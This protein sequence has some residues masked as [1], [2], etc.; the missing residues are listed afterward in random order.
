MCQ[1][2]IRKALFMKN[3]NRHIHWL[4]KHAKKGLVC[5]LKVSPAQ[6][7]ICGT[8]FHWYGCWA[9]CVIQQG[10][11]DCS[12]WFCPLE[13]DKLGAFFICWLFPPHHLSHTHTLFFFLTPLVLKWALR[14]HGFRKEI[15]L[16][17]TCLTIPIN[18]YKLFQASYPRNNTMS[19]YHMCY[20]FT[21]ELLNWS[22]PQ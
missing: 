5:A 6:I 19:I 10:S 20:L 7:F 12:A 3:Q 18:V 4:G 13:D 1:R 17:G 9:L 15:L 21:V 2:L 22:P 16:L 8:A 11:A 14:F